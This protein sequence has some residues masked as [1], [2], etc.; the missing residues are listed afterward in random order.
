MAHKKRKHH[1]KRHHSGMGVS[2]AKDRRGHIVGEHYG[3]GRG[4][5]HGE[6]SAENAMPVRMMRPNNRDRGI[7]SEDFKNPCGLPYGA[8]QR[9]L[10]NGEYFSMNAHRIGDLYEQVEKTMREDASAISTLTRPTNW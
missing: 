3:R 10:G 5:H 8:I 4:E 6:G 1:S 2:Y 7:I 9:N